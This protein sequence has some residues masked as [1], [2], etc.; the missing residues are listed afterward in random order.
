MENTIITK[1][2]GRYSDDIRAVYQDLVC[3]GVGVNNVEK[4]VKSVLV[5]LAK[6]NAESLPK[7]TF[8]RLM[9]LEARR[10]SQIQVT[11]EIIESDQLNTLHTDGTSKFGHHF[12][13]YDVSLSSKKNFVLGLREVS[14]GDA[15]TQFECLQEIIDEVCEKDQTKVKQ[16][17]S[18]FRNTMSDR[19][20]VQK[21]FSK[22]LESYRRTILPEVTSNWAELSESEKNSLLIINDFFCGL[23]YMV[24][25]AD[26]AENTLRSWDKLIHDDQP[27][28]TLVH[29]G[30]SK[31]GESGTVRLVHT[32]CKS[33]KAKG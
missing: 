26:I 16:I 5:N 27:V 18:S 3:M 11:S 25:L 22:L 2:N 30:Y 7:S 23:H 33:V 21:N 10:L 14:S 9:F 4:I 17:F 29:G 12:E 15:N 28:S 6:M 19:H 31:G 20:I 24:G 8:A 32:L 13:T 1:E